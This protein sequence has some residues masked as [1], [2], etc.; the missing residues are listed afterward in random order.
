[1][2][3]TGHEENTGADSLLTE[4]QRGA[5]AAKRKAGELASDLKSSARN[6]AAEVRDDAIKTA[7]DGAAEAAEMGK[8]QT[9]KVVSSLGRA[10][11]AGGK[12]LEDDGLTGT[13]GY[14]RAAGKGLEDAA[15][16]I[17]GL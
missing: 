6:K 15:N 9:R 17:G 8:S 11:E 2:Q 12:S 4:A 13:A 10:L 1:M 7:R 14:V 3:N 5:S 16:E